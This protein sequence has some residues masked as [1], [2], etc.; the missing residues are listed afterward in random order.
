M[1]PPFAELRLLV[2]CARLDLR[3]ADRA[4][5]AAALREPLDWA[6]VLRLARWHGLRPLLHRHLA[7]GFAAQV[8][9]AAMV[10]LWAEA[11]AIARR[12]RAM[13][14]ELARVVRALDARGVPCLP[15]KGPTLALAAYGDLALREFADLDLLV[16]RAGLA[17][18]KAALLEA[19]YAPEPPLPPQLE[20]A[21]VATRAQYHLAMRSA[22]GQLVE[23]H[24][25]TDPD[26]P[27]QRERPDGWEATGTLRV[28]GVDLRVFGSTDLMAVLCL[29][30]S[31][32][33][34]ASLGWLVDVAELLRRGPP[35]DWVAID[36]RAG[37]LRCRRRVGLGLA[38][39]A[40][41]L[42][43]PLAPGAQA[44]AS[45]PG[46]APIAERIS[47]LLA[48]REPVLPG[49][50]ASL[51]VDIRMRE[52]AASGIRHFGATVF[53]PSLVEWQRW[54]LPRALFPLYPPL[55]LGR[56]AGKYARRGLGGLARRLGL[57]T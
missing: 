20:A 46:V 53:Q 44:L 26:C 51:R 47:R 4:A 52:G 13:A 21:F 50:L 42:G 23:L 31:K 15:Y 3:E 2:A 29:H 48:E 19:G 8:P 17:T 33:H 37:E 32:H 56:L 7:G 40:R 35:P 25:K 54:P 27:F 11:A 57:Q 24:W 36:R 10:E 45:H 18:A 22:E 6:L 28:E 49:P 41:L 34:W 16:H 1:N 30:G 14:R 39:A 38:L 5:L 12:N 9:R 55:R 43:A